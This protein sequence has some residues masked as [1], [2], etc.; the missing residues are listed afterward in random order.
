MDR[1][2]R[3]MGRDDRT[4]DSDD[5][6]MDRDAAMRRDEAPSPADADHR[7]ETTGGIRDVSGGRAH[8]PIDEDRPASPADADHRRETT[9]GIR[10]ESEFERG[11]EVGHEE[12][13]GSRRFVSADDEAR[14]LEQE[15]RPSR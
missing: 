1:D 5:R 6:T 13:G 10:D 11:R 7:R 4:S 15:R 9:G 8:E 14:D 3:T 12:S 2:D